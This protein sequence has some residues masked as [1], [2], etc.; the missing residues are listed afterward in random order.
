MIS[1]NNRFRVENLRRVTND[2][3]SESVENM[4]TL[5]SADRQLIAAWR[6]LN[7][8]C[9]MH[10]RVVDRLSILKQ[11]DPLRY[12]T[13]KDVVFYEGLVERARGNLAASILTVTE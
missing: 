5:T 7:D 10:R 4:S 1:E 2:P 6:D 8:A 9:E 12:L 11:S 13:E 3:A